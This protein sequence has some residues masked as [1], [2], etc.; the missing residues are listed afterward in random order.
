MTEG[1]LVDHPDLTRSMKS[2]YGPDA[3]GKALRV[4]GLTG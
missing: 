4:P 3:G 2:V 1:S